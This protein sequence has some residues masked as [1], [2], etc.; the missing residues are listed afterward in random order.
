[1]ANVEIATPNARTQHQK[2]ERGKATGLVGDGIR[3]VEG[4]PEESV[5][6]RRAT[7]V[8]GRG[9][10]LGGTRSSGEGALDRT[11]LDFLPAAT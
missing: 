7:R 2:G 11:W 5:A 3:S 8:K 1:M 9:N 6:Y 10:A 4:R